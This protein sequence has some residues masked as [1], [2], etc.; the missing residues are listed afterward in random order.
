MLMSIS[1]VYTT[2]IELVDETI[3]KSCTTIIIEFRT[4]IVLYEKYNCTKPW[5]Y[6]SDHR[7]WNDIR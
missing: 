7:R 3:N 2:K 5:M 1:Y 6:K 4:I